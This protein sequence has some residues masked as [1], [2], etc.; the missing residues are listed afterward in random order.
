LRAAGCLEAVLGSD[1]KQGGMRSWTDAANLLE[2]HGLPCLIFGAGELWPAHSDD[3]WVDLADLVRLS[4]ILAS[5][6]RSY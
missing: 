3:E 6:L 5:F 1:H 2:Y 4:Q